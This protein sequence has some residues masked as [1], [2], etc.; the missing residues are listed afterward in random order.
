M[1]EGSV[2]KSPLQKERK[3]CAG[4]VAPLTIWSKKIV[5][6]RRGGGRGV[7]VKY[8]RETCRALSSISRG[9]KGKK[10]NNGVKVTT[11]RPGPP[12]PL[13]GGG[14]IGV[15]LIKKKKKKKKQNQRKKKRGKE[16]FFFLIL[17]KKKKGTIIR[18]GRLG[19][20]WAVPF[21]E[22]REGEVKK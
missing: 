11:F 2:R 4:G 6:P 12:P 15:S 8:V 13:G 5:P 22:F 10:G 14:M 3:F 16:P 17:K 18:K 19:W 1:L 7:V 20:V 21:L 9:V